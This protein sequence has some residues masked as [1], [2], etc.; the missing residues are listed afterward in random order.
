MRKFAFLAMAAVLAGGGCAEGPPTGA[1][2]TGPPPCETSTVPVEVGGQPV[3]A[4][5]TACPQPDGSWRI[6]QQTPGLPPQVYI[7]PAPPPGEYPSSYSDD[8]YS[9]YFD[10][11]PL[12]GGPWLWGIGPSVVVV[13][14]VQHFQ[15]FHQFHGFHRSGPGR[16]PM[17]NGFAHM[18]VAPGGFAAHR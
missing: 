13:Q 6:T 4:T 1:A 9:D 3:Q 18:A 12:W 15:H 17:P 8:F 5:V 7:A 10:Y 14:R 11:W 2:G 16:P